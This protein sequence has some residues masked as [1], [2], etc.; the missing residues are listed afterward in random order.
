MWHIKYVNFLMKK[1]K[2]REE[3][4]LE[5]CFNDVYIFAVEI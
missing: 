2:K 5:S 3:R 4:F 1:E